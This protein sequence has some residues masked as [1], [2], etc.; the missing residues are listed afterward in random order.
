[1]SFRD[2][3]QD[4]GLGIQANGNTTSHLEAENDSTSQSHHPPHANHPPWP[5]MSNIRREEV[6]RLL[7]QGLKEIGYP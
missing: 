3:L 1:M 4:L 5:H 7:L 6:V 2:G